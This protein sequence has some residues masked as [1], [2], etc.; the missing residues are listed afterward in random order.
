MVIDGDCF[1]FMFMF[2]M[3]VLL[4]M[5]VVKVVFSVFVIVAAF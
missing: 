5:C 4:L 3:F 1:M 2:C